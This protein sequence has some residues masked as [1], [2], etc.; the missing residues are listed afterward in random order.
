MDCTFDHREYREKS[1]YNAQS[2]EHERYEDARGVESVRCLGRE[3]C[4]FVVVR[5][6]TICCCRST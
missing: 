1:P 2:V 5:E 3:E 6:S 4:A